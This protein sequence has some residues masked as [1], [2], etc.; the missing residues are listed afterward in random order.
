MMQPSKQLQKN[1]VE[2]DSANYIIKNWHCI[3]IKQHKMT[4]FI[5]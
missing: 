5:F 2:I 4:F 1:R 3:L